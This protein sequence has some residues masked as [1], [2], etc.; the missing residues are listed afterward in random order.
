VVPTVNRYCAT[1]V[2]PVHWKVT[3]D[4]VNLDPGAGVVSCA[5]VVVVT[6]NATPVLATPPAVTTTFPVIAVAGTRTLMLVADHVVGVAAMP[7]K[8]TLPWLAPK[9]TPV[10]V[11]AV[12]IGPAVGDRL[13]MLGVDPGTSKNTSAENGLIKA[14]VS[15]A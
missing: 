8:V 9:L 5:S 2:P 11:T 6:V 15:Y 10:I 13:V 3:V 12:P 14:D 7:L 4:A 1:P